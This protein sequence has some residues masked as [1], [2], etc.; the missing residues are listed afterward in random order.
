MTCSAILESDFLSGLT[1]LYNF[2]IIIFLILSICIL[3]DSEVKLKY[4][5]LTS[6]FCVGVCIALFVWINQ[7]TGYTPEEEKS[8]QKYNNDYPF[9]YEET[10]QQWLEE[11]PNST[12][13]C[14]Y[15][16]GYNILITIREENGNYIIKNIINNKEIIIPINQVIV[17]KSENE[18]TIETI[19]SRYSNLNIKSLID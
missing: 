9:Q 7:P 15:I 2:I 4:K 1:P 14:A 3:I 16:N 6:F 17:T 13:D 12:Y 11:N 19:N 8:C 10:I 5:I 18:L